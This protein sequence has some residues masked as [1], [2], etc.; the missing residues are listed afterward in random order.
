[1]GTNVDYSDED[2]GNIISFEHVN[3]QVPDQATAT[4]FYVIGLGLTRDPYISVGLD[5]MWVNA[6]EQQFHLPTRGTQVIAGRL[7]WWCPI[8]I[9]YGS[10][11]YRWN[12]DWPGLSLNGPNPRTP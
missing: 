7:G 8:W 12:R 3:L 10:A 2:V 11:W 5:S 1:M 6:G 4:L 9:R